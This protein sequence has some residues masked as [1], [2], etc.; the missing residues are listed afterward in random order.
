MEALQEALQKLVR[1]VDALSVLA[2]DPDH[3]GPGMG[4]ECQTHIILQNL[5]AKSKKT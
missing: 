1:V 4:D 2:D 3:G 5:S